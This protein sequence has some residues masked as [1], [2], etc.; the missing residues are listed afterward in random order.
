MILKDCLYNRLVV[1][2]KDVKKPWP[3]LGQAERE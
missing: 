2:H 3:R 1:L